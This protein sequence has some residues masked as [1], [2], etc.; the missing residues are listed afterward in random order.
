MSIGGGG[1]RALL[2]GGLGA[3]LLALGAQSASADND[4][5]PFTIVVASCGQLDTVVGQPGTYSYTT[6]SKTSATISGTFTT[7]ERNENV[8]V[9]GIYSNGLTTITVKN[10]SRVVATS[11]WLFV[12]CATPPSGP[13]GPTGPTG[14]MGA[15]GATGQGV[16]GAT[17]AT[18]ATGTPGSQGGTGATGTTGATGPDL[19]C[20]SET[21]HGIDNQPTVV[22][23]GCN[24]QI[25]N[26][27]GKTA[28]TNGEGN[29]V[30]GYD[31][32][33]EEHNVRGPGG[34][35]CFVEPPC[36]LAPQTGSHNLI[37][38]KE[39]S[40]TR[41]GG[42]IAGQEN[43][44]SGPFAS[45][46]GGMSNTAT[47]TGASVSAGK[48]NKA[49]GEG[50]SVSGGSS[51]KASG[52]AASVGGGYLNT[53]SGENASV[54]GGHTDEAGGLFASASG[55]FGNTASG[56][57][58]SVSGGE[59]NKASGE[60]AAVS[61]GEINTAGTVDAWVGGGL[62]NEVFSSKNTGEEGLLAAIFGGKELKTDKND[63]A[64]GGY[65]TKLNC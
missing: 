25:V 42:I 31:E 19:A 11:K 18:G 54:S 32:L 5:Y 26:G 59:F 47:G 44:I 52:E 7:T 29:L 64:C 16:T 8:T 46:I 21:E 40:Y 36:P 43:T 39:Q 24:V 65:P 56:V 51:N 20:M 22:F 2:L 61:G 1:L 48:E 27:L 34:M 28:T 12:K 41:Y 10:G 14:P 57:N 35:P 38:G 6:E 37:L 45:V 9:G 30:I 60:D 53:A 33:R 17:G 3:L 55:G 62:G 4:S 63:E 23:N 58:A 15:T 49:I 13:A 50:A